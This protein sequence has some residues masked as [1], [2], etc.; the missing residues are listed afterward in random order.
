MFCEYFAE[1]KIHEIWQ[2]GKEGATSPNEG[3]LGPHIMVNV[4]CVTFLCVGTYL[5]V[6]LVS[7]H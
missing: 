1:K 4:F 5:A 3:L 6:S 2:R 7:N